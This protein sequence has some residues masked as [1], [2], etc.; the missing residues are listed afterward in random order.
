M[1]SIA[2]PARMRRDDDAAGASDHGPSR[3]TRRIRW[4]IMAFLSAISETSANIYWRVGGA[5][6]GVVV[7]VCV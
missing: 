1:S 3:S 4:P 2:G 7:D 5:F 6:G